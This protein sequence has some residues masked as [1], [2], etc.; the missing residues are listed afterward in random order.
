MG[1]APPTVVLVTVMRVK[2]TLTALLSLVVLLGAAVVIAV[3][4]GKG[5]PTSS[6]GAWQADAEPFLLPLR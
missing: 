6:E 1:W 5:L 2:A 4:A 3:A